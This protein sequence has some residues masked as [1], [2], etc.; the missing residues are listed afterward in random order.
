MPDLLRVR[1]LE[2]PSE[3][4]RR[5]PGCRAHELPVPTP[6]VRA[7]RP[8]SSHSEFAASAQEGAAEKRESLMLFRD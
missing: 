4:E 3:F 2:L 8:R 5:V 7:M 1:A 6:R